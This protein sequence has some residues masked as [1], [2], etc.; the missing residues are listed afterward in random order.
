M[1][2]KKIIAGF[3]AVA[4]AAAMAGAVPFTGANL[5]DTAVQASAEEQQTLSDFI[6][7]KF[8]SLSPSQ[9]QFMEQVYSHLSLTARSYFK[10]LKVA[11][12]IAD[13]A[14][15]EKISRQDLVEAVSFKS[16]QLSGFGEEAI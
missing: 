1:K 5:L 8:C 7:E 3:S 15:R 9:H 12:T 13:L 4:I 11:R 6:A 2:A 10:I 14:G 16:L